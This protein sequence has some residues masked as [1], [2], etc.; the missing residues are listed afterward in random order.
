M[1]H[2]G[3][4]CKDGAVTVR[5][6]AIAVDRA[7]AAVLASGLTLRGRISKGKGRVRRMRNVF[8]TR[9]RRVVLIAPSG[10][11]RVGG[12]SAPFARGIS[13]GHT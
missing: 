9:V 5:T 6:G 8:I 13:G 2:A 7:P 4:R 11:L 1:R 12:T 3:A 10:G